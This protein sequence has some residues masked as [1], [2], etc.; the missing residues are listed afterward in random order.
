MTLLGKMP[1]P[2]PANFTCTRPGTLLEVF[3]RA[4]S[5]VYVIWSRRSGRVLVHVIIY[6]AV[7]YIGVRPR[8]SRTLKAS[9]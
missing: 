6:D 8:T 1:A 4:D 2:Q 3:S 7:W 5:T 9:A